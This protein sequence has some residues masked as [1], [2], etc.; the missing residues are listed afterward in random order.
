M[1]TFLII[2]ILL[3]ILLFNEYAISTDE[4]IKNL[5][6]ELDIERKNKKNERD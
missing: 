3:I 5:E 4:K 2:L 1:I 6:I